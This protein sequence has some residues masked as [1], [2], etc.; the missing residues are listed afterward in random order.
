[1]FEQQAGK[2]FFYHSEDDFVVP[3]AHVLEYQKNIPTATYRF[4]KDLAHF[5][6]TEIPG[7]IDDIKQ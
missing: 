4:F 3:F 6:G 2:L 1:M 7:L 5:F